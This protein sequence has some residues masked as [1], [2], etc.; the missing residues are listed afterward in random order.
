MKVLSVAM[1]ILLVV[2]CRRQT[3]LPEIC[4]RLNSNRATVV[5]V[6]QAA[7]LES[8]L[9]RSRWWQSLSLEW[10]AYLLW[11]EFGLPP[12]LAVKGAL[13]DYAI[14]ELIDSKMLEEGSYN[15]GCA[16]FHCKGYKKFLSRNS[17]FGKIPE[18]PTNFE[19]I[20]KLIR[21][22]AI[23]CDS[24]PIQDISHLEEF[25]CLSD[26]NLSNMPLARLNASLNLYGLTIYNTKV[27]NLS[28]FSSPNLHILKCHGL[29]FTKLDSMEC[30]PELTYLHIDSTSVSSLEGLSKLKKLS[31]V[32]CFATPLTSLKGIEHLE[33]LKN[34]EN[35]FK[36]LYCL[37]NPH[38]PKAEIERIEKLGI[39]CKHIKE[40]FSYKYYPDSVWRD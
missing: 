8:T 20:H 10:K 15:D 11:R 37:P 28:G 18:L 35:K 27:K 13:R 2:S 1:V 34:T 36:G 3:P 9:E 19:G 6:L 23:K 33:Q 16:S 32:V 40:H 26:L 31:T 30:F 24:L 38:L 21:I 12:N 22:Q 17:Y 25:I 4:Q 7:N 29:D 14:I 5:D 39:K